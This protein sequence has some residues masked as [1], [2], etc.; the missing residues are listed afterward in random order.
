MI[1]KLLLI[2]RNEA[3]PNDV[4][5]SGDQ[6]D[7]IFAAVGATFSRRS[8]QPFGAG[9]VLGTCRRGSNPKTSVVDADQRGRAHPN[10]FRL[11]SG[12]FP[13]VGTA[14]PMLTIAALPWAAPRPSGETGLPERSYSAV[15][16]ER[17]PLNPHAMN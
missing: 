1:P 14:N 13:A 4:A 5:N 16:Y 8:E 3:L 17:G 11:G 9:H 15:S 12:A 10:L 2:S 7:C 6:G